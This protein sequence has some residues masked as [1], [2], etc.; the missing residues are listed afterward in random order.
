MQADDL[1]AGLLYSRDEIGARGEG[2]R[3]HDPDDARSKL[4]ELGIFPV[5]VRALGAVSF[6]VRAAHSA[7]VE[8]CRQRVGFWLQP[9]RLSGDRDLLLRIIDTR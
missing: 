7:D 9:L 3:P 4:E 1:A 2:L 8:T 5:R 6:I